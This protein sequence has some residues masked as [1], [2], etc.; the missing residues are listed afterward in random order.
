[1][2]TAPVA[3]R[4]QR[5]FRPALLPLEGRRLLSTITVDDDRKQD[6]DAQFTSIQ[7]AVLAAAPNDTIRVYPGTYREQ[8]TI[9]AG[10]DGLTL[11]SVKAGKATIQAPAAMTGLKSIVEVD[12]HNVEIDGF[13]IAG[14]SQGI[15]AGVLVDQG[16]S[17][18]IQENHITAIR[19][20]PLSGRQSGLAVYVRNGSARILDNVIDD[21]QKA[22]IVVNSASSSAEIAFNTVRGAGPTTATA[23]DG[24]Q[25]SF[26]ATANIHDNTVSDNVYSVGTDA[27]TGILLFHPGS[28][29][30]VRNNT[31]TKN[32]FGIYLDGATGATVTGNSVSRNTYDGIDLADGTTGTLV[33][34]ND[35]SKNGLDGILVDSTSTNNTIRDNVFK[36][37]KNFDAE[38]QS[39]GA[40][41]AGTA[42]TWR[43]NQGKTSNPPGLVQKQGHGH[44]DDDHDEDEGQDDGP[45]R[46][47]GRGH[48]D[49]V[50][51]NAMS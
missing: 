20:E 22:G 21:Y 2:R 45:P 35:S 39:T 46:A 4:S 26:G 33:A 48:D 38:D 10:K 36:Q 6:K 44:Q 12:A 1:M 3:V 15:N 27:A 50:R 28:A 11:T 18:T 16:G 41:T 7:A 37:N 30:T 43:N 5:G 29:V 32:D 23:Q 14:P 42:N 24:I 31:V 40:G 19:D 13:T 34:N 9:P 49:A 47:H 8:V 17:A 25:V 51:E